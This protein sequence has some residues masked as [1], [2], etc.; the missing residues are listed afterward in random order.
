MLKPAALASLAMLLATA[1]CLSPAATPEKTVIRQPT[2]STKELAKIPTTTTVRLSSPTPT[3]LVISISA[4]APY[5]PE[6]D[7]AVRVAP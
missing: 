2:L 5:I 3:V 6:Y 7:R 4:V 1:A